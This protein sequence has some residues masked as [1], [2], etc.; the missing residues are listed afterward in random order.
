LTGLQVFVASLHPSP[1]FMSHVL[2][3]D[4]NGHAVFAIPIAV[5]HTPLTQLSPSSHEM[6]PPHTCPASAWG[7]HASGVPAHE[8]PL[9]QPVWAQGAPAPGAG[10][11]VPQ[12]LPGAVPQ[13]PLWH[14]SRTAHGAPSGSAPAGGRHAGG[15]FCE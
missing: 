6:P 9:G 10:P 14:C 3:L 7:W 15:G 5:W 2:V 13:K 11:H 12:A 1:A 8:K 4:E